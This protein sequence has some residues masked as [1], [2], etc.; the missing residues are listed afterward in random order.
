M[1]TVFRLLAVLP[2]WL[3]HVMGVALGWVALLASPT[4]R[5]RFVANAAQAGYTLRQVGGAVG[6]AG[7]LIAEV[8]RL[9]FGRPPPVQWSGEHLIDEALA[10]GRG[11]VFLTPHLGCFEAT[12]QGYAARYGRI[13]VLYR[14][15]RKAWLRPLVDQAR[16]RPNLETAPTTLAGVKQMLKALQAGQ[17]VGLLPD[18]VPPQ[19]LGV[20]APFFGKPAYTMTLSARLARQTGAAVLLAWGERLRWGRGYRI[21]LRPWPGAVP[22]AP[23]AAAVGVNAQMEALVRECPAQYLW[24]YARYKAPRGAA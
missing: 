21:H 18:Q 12:A 7:Q 2:L 10:R 8:P 5:R 16:R 19:G 14:P 24:G 13:T 23:D 17:A 4:Y 6:A 20:W 3:L 9:W 22:E 11:I 1:T 15:A